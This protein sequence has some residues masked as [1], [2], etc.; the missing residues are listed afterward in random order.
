VRDPKP[1]APGEKI[2]VRLFANGEV[3][4]IPY[5]ELQWQLYQRWRKRF[6]IEERV[7]ERLAVTVGGK[8]ATQD[9]RRRAGDGG[10]GAMTNE[11]MTNDTMT[12]E[13]MTNG[14]M[15]NEAMTNDAMTEG[16]EG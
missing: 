4:V 12:N 3:E 16:G 2:A 15:T 5:H 8:A 6:G 14:S 7:E 11:A 9:A 10:N 1:L 13:P